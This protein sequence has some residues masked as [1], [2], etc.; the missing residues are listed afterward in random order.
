MCPGLMSFWRETNYRYGYP[1]AVKAWT[2]VILVENYAFAPRDC[3][4]NN[5]L[6]LSRCIHVVLQMTY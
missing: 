2:D 5:S 3:H 1:L 6:I 4:G